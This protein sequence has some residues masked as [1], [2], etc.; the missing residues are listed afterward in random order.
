VGTR[1]VFDRRSIA[2]IAYNGNLPSEQGG[3]PLMQLRTIELKTGTV[4][5][6]RM[7]AL[8]DWNG[9]LWV[10]DDEILFNRYN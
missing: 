10:S 3:A 7:H 5:N 2:F 1:L 6:L 9:P 8:T 4:S